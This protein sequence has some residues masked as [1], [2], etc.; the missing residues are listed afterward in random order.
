M[1]FAKLLFCGSSL[2]LFASIGSAVPVRP[3]Q[4][5]SE[6]GQALG[7]QI[8]R[9]EAD[10][11]EADVMIVHVTIANKSE[12]T[13]FEYAISNGEGKASYQIVLVDSG[14]FHPSLRGTYMLRYATSE[15]YVEGVTLGSFSKSTTEVKF[16]FTDRDSN[17]VNCTYSWSAGVKKYV[18]VARD[19]PDIP[20]PRKGFGFGSQRVL[21][22]R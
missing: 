21:R 3:I 22:A 5:D 12:K 20:R 8:Y 13:E 4:V 14:K 1:S 15:G 16:G 18:D 17:T 9:F 6:L 10:L 2:A 11:T 7:V 19:W